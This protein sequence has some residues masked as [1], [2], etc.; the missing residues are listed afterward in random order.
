MWGNR[1]PNLDDFTDGFVAVGLAKAWA[2]VSGSDPGWAARLA[3]R[4][5]LVVFDEAHQ[6][7]AKTYTADH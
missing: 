6:S 4:V 7:I 3:Q 5:R 2:V 1:T